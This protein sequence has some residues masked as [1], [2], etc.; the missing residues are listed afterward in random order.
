MEILLVLIPLS[1]L[2]VFGAIAMFFRA[3]DSGQFEDLEHQGRVSLFEDS[4][5]QLEGEGHAPLD[6]HSV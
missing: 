3:V 1:G 4:E 6:R 5:R 2:V